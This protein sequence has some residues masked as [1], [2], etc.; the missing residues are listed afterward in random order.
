[1]YSG[2][3]RLHL[4]TL[5][6]IG[7]DRDDTIMDTRITGIEDMIVLLCSCGS[8]DTREFSY[9]IELSFIRKEC[10]K[11]LRLLI[12]SEFIDWS[13]DVCGIGI[14][15]VFFEH[16]GMSDLL[17]YHDIIRE[18]FRDREI[19]CECFIRI[20]F[21]GKIIS[22]SYRVELLASISDQCDTLCI[23]EFFLVFFSGYECPR[24]RRPRKCDS[25]TRSQ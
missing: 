19:I 9:T 8:L 21:E 16:I 5:T 10:H 7:F 11:H 25:R 12:R 6:R 14:F 15:P 1:M 2:L 23:G 20:I 18:F 4:D 17:L 3:E 24:A 13:T 22:F